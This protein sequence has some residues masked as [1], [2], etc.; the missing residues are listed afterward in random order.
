MTGYRRW[1]ICSSQKAR[2]ADKAGPFARVSLS[3]LVALILV[4]PASAKSNLAIGAEIK[5]GNTMPYSGAASAYGTIGRAEA[6]YFRMLNGQGGINGRKIRFL[7]VDDGYSPPKTLEET[8]RLIESDD[9]LLM[10]SAFGTATVSA[11]QR[12][13]AG[14]KIPQLFFITGASKWEDRGK[15]PWMV[16]WQPTYRAEAMMYA[17]YLV[18]AKPDAKIGVL[19]QNDD[20]GKDYLRGLRDGLGTKADEMIVKELTYQVGDPTINSQIV[21][22]QASGANVFFDV[23]T[24]KFAAQAIRKSSDIGWHPLHLLNSISSSVATVLEPAGL[25]K[26]VG[27]ISAAYGKDPSDPQFKEDQGVREYIAFMR[28]YYPDGD[29]ASMNNVVAY[30]R[31]MTLAQVLRQCNDDLTRENIMRQADNLDL[32]LPML[33]PGIRVRTGAD[34]S[35]AITEMQLQRFDGR[36]WERFGELIDQQNQPSIIP[37]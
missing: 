4:A 12:Y 34:R 5:I 15:F 1:Q 35:S 3:L 18:H 8:R 23:T 28:R 7:S 25:D 32:E 24:A 16:G 37:S 6:A 31:A 27:I 17:K 29:P 10:F 30:S 9:V 26:A 20:Y 33:L 2:C 14:H 22:L 11:V 36:S 19:Y 21:M 13:L